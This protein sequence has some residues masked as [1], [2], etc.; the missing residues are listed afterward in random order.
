M[1]SALT[2]AQERLQPASA[3]SKFNERVK[4]IGKTNSEIADWLQ[5]YSIPEEAGTASYSYYSRSDAELRTHMSKDCE[6]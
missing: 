3:V 6:S 4:R 5:V 2:C 1:L